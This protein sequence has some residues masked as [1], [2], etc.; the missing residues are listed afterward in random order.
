VP[1]TPAR[2]FAIR[3]VILLGF[4]GTC[5]VKG[6]L[7][8]AGIESNIEAG[9]LARPQRNR[10][11][12]VLEGERRNR[13]DHKHAIRSRRQLHRIPSIRI[14]SRGRDL[15]SGRR[16]YLDHGPG[17]R[18]GVGDPRPRDRCQQPS[19]YVPLKRA[20]S[21]QGDCATEQTTQS[22]GTKQRAHDSH[23]VRFKIYTIVTSGIA[24]KTR[25]ASWDKR[26]NPRAAGKNR[27]WKEKRHALS[28]TSHL[29][30]NSCGLWLDL[31]GITSTRPMRR[32]RASRSLFTRTNR[33][34]LTW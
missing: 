7:S 34:T 2:D 11:G 14:A 13:R 5:L 22:G 33:P 24:G 23:L 21:G 17:D 15:F 3:P 31:L 18:R 27:R 19:A 28:T 32:W 8:D 29:L 4:C 16:R 10:R 30:V 12:G 20:R 1:W 26:R 6:E 25:A 9:G